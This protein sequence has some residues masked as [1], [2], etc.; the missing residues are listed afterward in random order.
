MLLPSEIESRSLIPAVRV[1]IAR[2]LANEHGM[3]EDKIA[4]ILGVT[5]AAVSNYVRGTR[6]DTQLV[7]KLNEIPEVK[8]IIDDI[9]NEIAKN[10][11]FRASTMAKYIG[12]FN[13]LRQSYI[14]CDV[15]HTLE[16]DI[17]E[18]ACKACESTLIKN[19][20]N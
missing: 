11:S 7:N 1:I 5:Q 6:G 8:R 13:Y 15:H 3:K 9:T 19:N 4:K 18:E 10:S 17:D 12:L 16:K 20:D 2:K 14:I